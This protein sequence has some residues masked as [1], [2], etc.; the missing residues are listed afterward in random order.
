M[1]TG[2]LR[3]QRLADTRENT[4]LIERA[5]NPDG[6]IKATKNEQRR[7]VRLLSPLAQDL[8]EYRL[9]IGRPP[10]TTLLLVDDDSKPWTKS[11]WQI[12]RSDRSAPACRAVGLDPIPR[13]YD[14]RHS[15]ASLLLAE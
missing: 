12:W 10:D 4:I 3:A 13:R 6:S 7:A 5:A 8:R 14:L 1:R 9:A 11:A 2:E 15:F